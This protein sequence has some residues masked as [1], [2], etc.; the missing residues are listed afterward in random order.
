M[1]TTYEEI[2]PNTVEAAKVEKPFMLEGVQ[3]NAG[4][5]LLQDPTNGTVKGVKA[6]EFEAQYRKKTWSRARKAKTA[7]G[8]VEAVEGNTS[9]NASEATNEVQAAEAVTV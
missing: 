8:D 9:E 1:F 6:V 7:E 2:S 4:D 5:Y 3:Y